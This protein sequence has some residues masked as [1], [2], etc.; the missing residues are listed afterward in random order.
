[1]TIEF[2]GYRTWVNGIGHVI[3]PASEFDADKISSL[4]DGSAITLAIST[5]DAAAA[6]RFYFGL[7]AKFVNAGMWP[8]REIADTDF[9]VRLGRVGSTFLSEAPDGTKTYRLQP[10]PRSDWT[11]TEWQEFVQDVLECVTVEI[12]PKI[13]W[14]KLRREIEDYCGVNLASALDDLSTE[15]AVACRS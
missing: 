12:T 13:L 10:I 11:I 14:P 8:H 7:I 9:M 15:E 1:M 3:R 6:R 5:R 4:K 2:V